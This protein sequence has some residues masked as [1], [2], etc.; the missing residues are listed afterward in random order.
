M[1]RGKDL[2]VLDI[3]FFKIPITRQAKNCNRL[4]QSHP[5]PMKDLGPGISGD[6][7]DARVDLFLAFRL[8]LS[9]VSFSFFKLHSDK[10]LT[11]AGR[12]HHQDISPK[13]HVAAVSPDAKNV[14]VAQSCPKTTKEMK[15]NYAK[16]NKL[17][18]INHSVQMAIGD[19]RITAKFT[20]LGF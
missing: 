11:P 16:A 12:Q 10:T 20:A 7:C 13:R 4:Y 2:S 15:L 18:L 19:L 6:I 5:H 1:G 8:W 17:D 14:T 9:V 3:Q